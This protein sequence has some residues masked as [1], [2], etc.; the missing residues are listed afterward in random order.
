MVAESLSSQKQESLAL[1]VED[2]KHACDVEKNRR[3]GFLSRQ[4]SP[5]QVSFRKQVI[6]CTKR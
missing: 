2:L 5:Y 1:E 3:F 4:D 6:A